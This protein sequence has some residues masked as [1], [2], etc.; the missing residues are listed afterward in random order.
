MFTTTTTTRGTPLV[1]TRAETWPSSPQ[2]AGSDNGTVGNYGGQQRP[3]DG[4]GITCRAQDASALNN[5]SCGGWFL[6]ARVRVYI[7]EEA[8]KARQP[9]ATQGEATTIRAAPL[10]FPQS[11][12]LCSCKVDS[13]QAENKI[14]GQSKKKATRIGCKS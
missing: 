3:S 2:A 8:G 9:K 10:Y 7:Y 11:I 13:S 12:Y 6:C 14:K 5:G 4:H 1:L